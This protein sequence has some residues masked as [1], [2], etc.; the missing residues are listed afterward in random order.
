MRLPASASQSSCSLVAG[1]FSLSFRL[2]FFFSFFLFFPPFFSFLPFPSPS[3]K[4]AARPNAITVE[5][6]DAFDF[7]HTHFTFLHAARNVRLDTSEATTSFQGAACVSPLSLSRWAFI[8]I[9]IH[10]LVDARSPIPHPACRPPRRDRPR[11]SE[12]E[13]ES[14]R[15]RE[16][17]LTLNI[18]FFPLH[19]FLL[20]YVSWRLKNTIHHSSPFSLPARKRK[21]TF[22]PRAAS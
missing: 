19:S 14:E 21:K 7:G 9:M 15:A 18:F 20:F 5:S 6:W 11:E 8:S 16:L 4:F 1:P 22:P 10:Y 2:S 12:R 13:S 17:F 3:A